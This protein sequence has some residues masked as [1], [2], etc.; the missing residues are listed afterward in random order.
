MKCCVHA[1]LRLL[2]CDWNRFRPWQDIAACGCRSTALPGCNLHLTLPRSKVAAHADKS[3]PLSWRAVGAV[4]TLSSQ[5]AD[6]AMVYK[7]LQVRQRGAVK[8]S[9]AVNPKP[10]NYQEALQAAGSLRLKFLSCSQM[11]MFGTS[12]RAGPSV[13]HGKSA[14]VSWLPLGLETL[15]RATMLLLN[16]T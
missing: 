6:S 2:F 15:S 14:M 1:W 9:K 12:Q 7:S 16:P 11:W 5:H 3:W 10:D 13:A 8:I 4:M